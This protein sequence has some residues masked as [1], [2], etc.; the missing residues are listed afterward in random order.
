MIELT[1]LQ[2]STLFM[3]A[4]GGSLC[5]AVIYP[6]PNDEEHRKQ[7]LYDE[8]QQMN[9]LLDAGLL[10]DLS[11]RFKESIETCK[12][13]NKGRGYK[14]FGLTDLAVKMFRDSADRQ[15]N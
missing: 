1:D 9:D 12:V 10:E 14:V 4:N 3:A 11:N 8:M 6:M 5:F 15:V 7:Y 13:N 2:Y